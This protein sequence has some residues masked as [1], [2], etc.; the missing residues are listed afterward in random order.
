VVKIITFLTGFLNIAASCECG[1]YS[2][3]E[4]RPRLVTSRTSLVGDEQSLYLRNVS[5]FLIPV[6]LSEEWVCCR[7]LVG[8]AG[9]NTAEGMDVCLL[10][11]LCVVR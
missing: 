6:V 9:S 3:L 10:L 7:S 11:V 8:F 4:V 1:L 2:A 5:I